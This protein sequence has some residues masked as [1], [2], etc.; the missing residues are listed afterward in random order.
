MRKLES[1]AM[2]MERKGG[3]GWTNLRRSKRQ[4]TQRKM[5]AQVRWL[6]GKERVRRGNVSSQVNAA[7]APENG[8]IATLTCLH[9]PGTVCTILL[10]ERGIALQCISGCKN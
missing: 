2:Q 8:S 1:M 4:R 6:N 5:N 10:E 3:V 9:Q 7:F